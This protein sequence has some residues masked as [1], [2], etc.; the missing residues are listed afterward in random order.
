M[1]N[2]HHDR[3]G[4]GNNN[5]DTMPYYPI[6]A[7]MPDGKLRL[8]DADPDAMLAFKAEGSAM[9]YVVEI[10]TEQQFE[11]LQRAFREMGQKQRDKN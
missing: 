5:S 1:P 3:A 11:E 8:I 4:G 9:A 7:R 2:F 6:V 10:K